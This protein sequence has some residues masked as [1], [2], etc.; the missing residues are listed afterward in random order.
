MRGRI[1]R[2]GDDDRRQ[3][4]TQADDDE[5]DRPTPEC[6]KPGGDRRAH[7]AGDDVAGGVY[8]VDALPE[9]TGNNDGEEAPQ[10]CRRERRRERCD[11][12]DDH[13]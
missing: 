1:R 10:A 6:D 5:R 12:R 7:D 2:T 3:A 8:R 9:M 11:G 13:E 4:E